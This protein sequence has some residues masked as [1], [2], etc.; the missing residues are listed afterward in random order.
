MNYTITTTLP[1][2]LYFFIKE[3]SKFRKTT[4]KTI[5]KEAVENY[6]KQKLAEDIKKGLLERQ[7]ELKNISAEFDSAQKIS[8]KKSNE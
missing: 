7:K 4:Y 6:K 1:K 5:L 3:E 2:D 8:F